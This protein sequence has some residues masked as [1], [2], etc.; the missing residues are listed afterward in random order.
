MSYRKIKKLVRNPNLFFFDY[1]KHKIVSENMDDILTVVETKPEKN[2]S[3]RVISKIEQSLN[4]KY[5][6]DSVSFL[7]EG[8]KENITRYVKSN[9][10]LIPEA[11]EIYLWDGYTSAFVRF[12][13]F[14]KSNYGFKIDIYQSKGII[15]YKYDYESTIN[16]TNLTKALNND[17]SFFV[18]LINPL[19]L[20]VIFNI[21]LCKNVEPNTFMV[22]SNGLPFKKFNVHAV[23]LK[24]SEVENMDID[25]VYTWVNKDDPSWIN[26]WNNEYPDNPIDSDRFSS[27][28]ELRYSLRSI[29]MYAPWIRNIYIVSN[30]MPPSWLDTTNGKVQW[31]FHDDIYPSNEYLPVFNSHSIETCLH[32][33]N[34]LSEN[35]IYFND[36]VFL[37]QPCQPTD[38]FDILGRSYSFYEPYGMVGAIN[39]DE[40]TPSYMKAATNGAE[41]IYES[42]GHYPR[43]LLKH[44]PHPLKKSVLQEIEDIYS[45]VIER[46]RK[47]KL[48]SDDDISLTSFFFH[49]YSFLNGTSVPGDC[50]YALVRA[51]NYKKAFQQSFSYKFMCLNDGGG[52]SENKA[53]KTASLNFMNQRF[54]LVQPWEKK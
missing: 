45:N 26:L 24:T 46:V 50:H 13:A 38:F 27:N 29:A 15:H 42:Y 17:N 2:N 7:D 10:S 4:D 3:E 33:I 19:G 44:T 36:D 31:V 22:R 14:S 54:P 9:F 11:K 34:G 30:C 39:I 8:I 53:Y 21:H 52:D 20:H 28:D 6:I 16:I 51:K 32:K 5:L 47:A 35:F 41:I 40:D 23:N 37:S 1:F 43:N 12:L 48:R 18:E 49:H 25:A